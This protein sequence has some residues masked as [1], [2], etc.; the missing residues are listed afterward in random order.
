ME[1]VSNPFQACN[2][3]YFKPNRVFATLTEKHNWSWLAF[4]FVITLAILPS[5][6]YFN[7]IDFEWYRELIINSTFADVSPAE[8]DAVRN[9]ITKDQTI[10]FSIIGPFVGMIF[11]NAILAVY[12]NLATKVDEENLNGFTDWYG[13]TWWVSM[14]VIVSSLAGIAAIL[15][16][17]SHQ[18][19]PVTLGPT[20]LA[21]VL[22]IE[23]GSDWFSLTQSIRLESFWSMYLIAVGVAQWTKIPTNKCYLIAA[24]PYFAVWAI[25]AAIVAI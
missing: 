11:I 6:F 15:L 17:D 2:D 4:I 13:F 20:T 18:L 3:I 12:L 16:A 23:L 19:S 24:A 8:Q 22:G 1:T 5:Y 10:M 9:S 25:W 21:F 14:P 7:F